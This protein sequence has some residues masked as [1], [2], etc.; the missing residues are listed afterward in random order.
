M[1]Y[2]G[3]QNQC[4]DCGQYGH[5]RRTCPSIKEAHAKVERLL[6]KYDMSPD[7]GDYSVTSWAHALSSKVMEAHGLQSHAEVHATCPQEYVSG[8]EAYRWQELE[9]REAEKKYRKENKLNTRRCGFCGRRGHNRRKCESLEQHKLA[10]RA[11]KALAHRVAR[12]TF[13]KSGVVPGA[14]VQ[15]REWNYQTREYTQRVGMIQSINWEQVGCQDEKEANGIEQGVESWIFRGHV[16]KIR[17]A[18]GNSRDVTMPR[19]IEQQSDYY[20]RMDTENYSLLSPVHG[21]RVNLDGYEG[22]NRFPVTKNLWLWG[23]GWVDKKFGREVKKL[24]KEVG[25]EIKVS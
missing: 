12:L 14:L 3:R 2:T 10:C 20:H 7:P 6:K 16:L 11:M 19:N 15:Y 13:E 4:Q 9:K 17:D 5:N 18:G 22:D 1:G 21:A 25:V 24:A 23:S 8:W